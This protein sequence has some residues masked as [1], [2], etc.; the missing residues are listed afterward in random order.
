MTAADRV[1][2][3]LPRSQGSLGPTCGSDGPKVVVPDLERGR[4]STSPR[5]P[6]LTRPGSLPQQLAALASVYV[7]EGQ[8]A[9][10]AGQ[11]PG[12]PRRPHSAILL[13]AGAGMS[14]RRLRN[15]T[16]S[17]HPT[18]APL[19]RRLERPGPRKQYE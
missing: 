5:V 1:P 13:A 11:C 6:Y 17:S 4:A 12:L 18:V 14:R 3:S 7:Q 9:A 16:M 2:I 8:V 10:T 15:R 19:E